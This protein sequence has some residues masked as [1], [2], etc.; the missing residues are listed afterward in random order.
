MLAP[1][2]TRRSSVSPKEVTRMASAIMD[3]TNLGDAY[4]ML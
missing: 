2:R 3:D 4:R 1:V